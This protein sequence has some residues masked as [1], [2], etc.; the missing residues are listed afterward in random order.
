MPAFWMCDLEPTEIAGSDAFN[1]EQCLHR[2]KLPDGATISRR[3]PS[4]RRLLR[5]LVIDDQRDTTDSLVRLAQK[6]G[7]T[8][9]S[10]YDGAQGLRVAFAQRP[11]VVLVDISMPHLDGLPS[12]LLSGR[13]QKWLRSGVTSCSACLK[14]ATVLRSNPLARTPSVSDD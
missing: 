5:V 12:M 1:Q 14:S 11:D 10:A 4:A 9:W 2:G 6:W 8:A 13:A 3:F 7:H